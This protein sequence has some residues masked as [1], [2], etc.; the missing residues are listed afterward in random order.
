MTENGGLVDA[1]KHYIIAMSALLRN[2][3]N[4]PKKSCHAELFFS[5]LQ[6]PH[7]QRKFSKSQKFS[8]FWNG[9][10]E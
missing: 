5:K 9:S 8:Q 10:N 2:I 6:P 1:N 4:M 3:I 7:A